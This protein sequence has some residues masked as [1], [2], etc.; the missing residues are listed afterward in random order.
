GAF[1][2]AFLDLR[3]GAADGLELLPK[4]LA[5]RAELPV[6]IV[7]AYATVDT[8]VAA[9]KR[10]AVDY[11]PKPFTPAQ[12]RHA[13]E[14]GTGRRAIERR[15][16]DLEAQLAAELPGVDLATDAPAMQAT[17]DL[18]ARAAA[19]DAPILL[20][21]ENGTGK[22]VLARLAHARSPRAAHPFVTV[23]CP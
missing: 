12:I 8:A 17:I 4:L 16:T 7:T 19:S 3:L 14:Q 20:R 9:L 6:V 23:N 10:G 1:D 21:G 22:G 13:V 11:L 2:L 18:V 15:V 5:V